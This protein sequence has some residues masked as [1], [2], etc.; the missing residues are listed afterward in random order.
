[1][2]INGE[3]TIIYL[4]NLVSNQLKHINIKKQNLAFHDKV[5][6]AQL[7]PT[8]QCL[9]L[10]TQSGRIALWSRPLSPRHFISFHLISFQVQLYRWHIQGT[11]GV[12]FALAFIARSLVGILCRW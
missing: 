9:A 7:H 12:V 3:G 8:E 5:T 1:M 6:C 11:D 4:F 10:G 2:F